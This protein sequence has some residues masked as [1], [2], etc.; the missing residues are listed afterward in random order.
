MAFSTAQEQYIK[1]IVAAF[2]EEYPEGFYFAYNDTGE[3]DADLHIIFSSD[4]MTFNGE[5]FD[6]FIDGVYYFSCAG[7]ILQIDVITSNVSNYNPNLSNRI[8]IT[9]FNTDSHVF[10]VPAYYTV[11]S[12]IDW[13]NDGEGIEIPLAG[14]LIASV[15]V[16]YYAV[17]SNIQTMS[18]GII[19]FLICFILFFS[20]VFGKR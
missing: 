8:Q 13:Y 12:N 15:G 14:D 1:S 5:Y 10:A 9:N 17:Q 6:E 11:S 3:S 20:W 4:S 18:L 19:G 7:N 16:D 2:L